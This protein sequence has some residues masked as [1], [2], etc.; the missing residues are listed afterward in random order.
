MENKYT[1]INIGPIFTTLSMARKPREL[2][3][4]SYLFSYLMGCI[5]DALPTSVEI[6][7]PARLPEEYMHLGIG[8][9]PDRL[10]LKGTF[11]K[12]TE[13]INT[14]W[15]NMLLIDTE[16][17]KSYFNI[18]TAECEADNDSLAISK[19]NRQM[20]LMELYQ[21]AKKESDIAPISKLLQQKEDSRLYKLATDRKFR[22]DSLGVIA[23]T[24]LKN[25]S[26]NWKQFCRAL[27]EGTESDPYRLLKEKIYS[28]N[29]YI[30]V[31]Q[32]DGD[33][34]G[35]TVSH[36]D[37]QNGKVSQ[38]SAS[39][40]AYAKEATD[41]IEDFGG[42]P[43]FAGGD[44]L[45][46]IAPVVGIDGSSIFDLINNIDRSFSQVQKVVADCNLMDE[47]NT[48]IAASMSYGVSISY[49]KF[50]LYEALGS[51]RTLLF[52][53]AKKQIK[54][55]NGIA[56]NLQKHSGSTFAG[57]LSKGDVE[58]YGAFL[59]VIENTGDE[60]TVSAVAH[61]IRSNGALLNLVAQ[62]EEN[63]EKRLD[64]LFDKYF[65]LNDGDSKGYFDSVKLLLRIILH[66]QAGVTDA[67]EIDECT[68]TI[69][70]MLRTAK[71][72]KGEEAKDE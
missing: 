18:M 41:I 5:I 70:G 28:Y 29:K 63:L 31:V 27:D 55:K 11:D 53:K 34:I 44:D 60:R 6:I 59:N 36:P 26:L 50:P 2:W 40:L 49:H 72:I 33:N 20:D 58:L 47:N 3:S 22:V 21:F 43:I 35:K 39:L 56:W 24:S 23:A 69:Y 12:S 14:A 61:K 45:L 48:P 52:D 62:D 37:L 19:L 65:E 15:K 42:M 16:L 9:Y 30:C 46:F 10:F 64:N 54:G 7:S 66:N 1:A 32:A 51:A 71:F 8:M 13:V 67:K 57:M 68:Q 4:A 25:K 38:I 17:S